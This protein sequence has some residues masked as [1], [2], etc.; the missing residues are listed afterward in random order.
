MSAQQLERSVPP[1]PIPPALPPTVEDQFV[2]LPIMWPGHGTWRVWLVDGAH[3]IAVHVD[4]VLDLLRI[5]DPAVL[6]R[7]PPSWWH[8]FRTPLDRDVQF[9]WLWS[10]ETVLELLHVEPGFGPWSERPAVELEQWLRETYRML[11]VEDPQ[12]TLDESLPMRHGTTGEEFP[13]AAAARRLAVRY[14]SKVTRGA[15][16]QLM[17]ERGWIERDT[18]APG[19]SYWRVCLA[20][21]ARGFVY[22][23]AVKIPGGS[24][25]QVFVT[26][27]GMAELAGALREQL[28]PPLVDL[29]APGVSEAVG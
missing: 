24:Y 22:S 15:L 27:A 11:C 16:F 20:G 21:R 7:F 1:F 14:G 3:T 25:E 12:R 17:H 23:R 10:Y 18:D 19:H 13:V 6:R 9:A 4:Q 8:E 2:S 5:L 26:Q 28:Q 29:T